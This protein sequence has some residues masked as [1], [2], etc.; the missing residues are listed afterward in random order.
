MG[1]KLLQ[2]WENEKKSF[3]RL[4]LK[5]SKFFQDPLFHYSTMAPKLYFRII[6]LIAIRMQ[7]IVQLFVSK[8][9]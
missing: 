2:C 4:I 9:L 6:A 7:K 3:Y 8:L 1:L 5:C